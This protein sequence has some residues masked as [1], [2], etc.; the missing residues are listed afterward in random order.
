MRLLLRWLDENFEKYLLIA[1]LVFIV[2]LIFLQVVLR[3]VFDSSLAWAEELARYVMLYQIWIGAAFAVKSDAHIRVTILPDRL[4]GK[5]RIKFEIILI[6]IWM[7]FAAFMTIKSGQLTNILLQR[8][9]LSTAMLIPMGYA[10]ASVPI[11]CG[12][13]VIRLAQK[14]LIE[15]KK[16]EEGVN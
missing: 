8:G 14:L 1:S 10:Y 13:M 6:A 9:Q 2:L 5:S 3:Y 7:V 16:L 12:L 15:L 11:G 4:K